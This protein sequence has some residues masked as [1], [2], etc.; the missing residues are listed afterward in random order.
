[1]EGNGISSGHAEAD[2]T[3]GACWDTLVH[4]WVIMWQEGI[5]NLT[6]HGRSKL[7]RDNYLC[8]PDDVTPFR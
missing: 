6:P 8:S 7:S 5:D 2:I 1:M 4:D 3:E